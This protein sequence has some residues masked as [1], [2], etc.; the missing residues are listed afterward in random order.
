MDRARGKVH[1]VYVDR[2]FGFIRCTEG[3]EGDVGQDYFFHFTGLEGCHVQDLEEGETVEFEPRLVAKGR[4]AER[5]VQV[6]G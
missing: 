4:R 1:R 5:I 3:A 2:G 6:R